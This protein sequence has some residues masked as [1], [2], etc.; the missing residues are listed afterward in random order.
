MICEPVCVLFSD[1][2]N[3]KLLLESEGFWVS[4]KG[5]HAIFSLDISGRRSTDKRWNFWMHVV[6][7]LCWAIWSERNNV[8]FLDKVV[9]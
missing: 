1:N 7:G 4:Q 8:T 2:L 6:P 3:V 9:V 5:M